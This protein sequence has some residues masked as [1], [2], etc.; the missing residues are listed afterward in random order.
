MKYFI[1]I[2]LLFFTF[3][4]SIAQSILVEYENKRAES[5]GKIINNFDVWITD[6]IATSKGRYG[7]LKETGF[8]KKKKEGF[9]YTSE[10]FFSKRF[11]VKDSL[12]NFKW[13]LTTDTAT[14]LKYKCVSAKTSFRGREYKVFYAPSIAVSDGPWKFGGLA[15]L[16]LE[17]KS[18]DGY[19]SWRAVKLDLAYK[20]SFQYVDTSKQT[21]LTWSG[22]VKAYREAV[23]KAIHAMRSQDFAKEGKTK[24]Q[25]PSIE[26]IHPQL[27][28]DGI[29]IGE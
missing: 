23:D 13:V 6:S 26:I 5:S 14:I 4:K 12:Y 24:L 29:D 10:S 25:V 21:Y 17:A 11:Y 20:G 19:V 1:V 16:I 7:N 9:L 28:R 18:K 8:V 2:L 22:L 3:S 15:G 27:N